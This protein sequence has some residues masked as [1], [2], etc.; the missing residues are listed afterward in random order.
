M[1]KRSK[2]GA[3]PL[4]KSNYEALA[5]FR[6]ALRAFLAFSVTAA[7]EAGLSPQ[8]H[9]ALL[10]I[11]GARGRDSLS[12]Q[13]IAARLMVRHH[14]AV[15]LVNR[16]E[17]LGLAKRARDV[18]DGRRVQVL[19]TQKA[20]HLLQAL[21]IAHLRELRGIRPALVALLEQFN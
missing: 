10:A 3:T 20:E 9:Q 1:S 13:D 14:S 7:S 11:K 21:S 8:Q 6:F 2:S 16:L 17:K 12:V 4:T 19:L 18:L 15:E 5:E